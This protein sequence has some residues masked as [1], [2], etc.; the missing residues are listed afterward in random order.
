MSGRPPAQKKGMR[1]HQ[2]K[3]A[4]DQVRLDRRGEEWERPSHYRVAS[5]GLMTGRNGPATECVLDQL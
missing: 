1:S 3:S 4:G 2:A 5:C